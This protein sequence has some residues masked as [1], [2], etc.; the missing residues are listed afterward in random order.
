MKKDLDYNELI[1]TAL[2]GALWG[3]IEISLGTILHASKIPFR[4][5]ALTIIAVVLITTS[6]SF[7]NYKGS[8]IAI[9]TVA[10]TLK[11]VTLPGFN[12]TPF[13]AILMQG[14]IAEIIFSFFNYNFISS[15]LA[16][17]AIMFYT[18]VHSL[19]MQGVFFGL[20]IYNVYIQVLNSAGKAINYEGEMSLI[21]IPV[22]VLLY[23]I[24]GAGAGWFGFT[25]A[26]R[27]KELL[28]ENV[29]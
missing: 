25:T 23:I 4:G 18:L 8:V 2:F 28:K 13:I 17:S 14:I 10:A 9:S 5:T 15:L 16:G 11:L 3:V 22:I 29:I 6:R 7:I 19:L 27:T 12:I 20:G 26:N 24:S 1:T 21:L